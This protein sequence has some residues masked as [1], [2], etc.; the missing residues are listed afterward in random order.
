MLALLRCAVC[1]ALLCAHASLALAADAEIAFGV[2]SSEPLQTLAPDWQPILDDLARHLGVNVKLFASPDR[3][4]VIAAIRANRVQVAWMGSEAA[5]EAVD[6]AGAEVF[7][8]T[9]NPDGSMGYRSV[10]SV[11]A[12]SRYS[13]LAALLNDTRQ[14]RFGIGDPNSTAGFLVPGLYLFARNQIDWRHAFKTV[15][16]ANHETNI[17]AL[18]DHEL[19][20][21]VHA[22]DAFDRIKAREPALAA[23]LRPIWQSPLI[24]AAPLV[25]RRDL[26]PQLKQKISDFFQRYGKLGVDAAAAKRHLSRLQLG[27]FERST[28]AQL[29]PVR[30]LLLFKQKIWVAVDEQLDEGQKQDRLRGLERQ[31]ADL[32]GP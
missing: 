29:L 12:D 1:A 17:R 20:A 26:S 15:R 23:R 7:A 22:S 19:D 30:Q 14:L 32:A 6:S 31:L 21:A 24:A 13:T 16:A 9:V 4:G 11:A 25:W 27:G 8:Q 3:A 28:N 5:I 18:A 2:I 10:L